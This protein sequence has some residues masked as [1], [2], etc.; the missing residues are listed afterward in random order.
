VLVIFLYDLS[1]L[2]YNFLNKIAVSAQMVLLLHARWNHGG[3]AALIMGD[4]ELGLGVSTKSLFRGARDQSGCTTS[5]PT[6][7]RMI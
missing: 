4:E 6:N 2:Y 5:V 7:S 1:V 3:A